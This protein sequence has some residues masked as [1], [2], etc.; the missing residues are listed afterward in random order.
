MSLLI[1]YLVFRFRKL[2]KLQ[3]I[4]DNIP[5]WF[6]QT[7]NSLSYCSKHDSQLTNCLVQG[8]N[9]HK[10]EEVFRTSRFKAANNTSNLVK[11]LWSSRKVVS[12]P[13]STFIES[14]VFTMFPHIFRNLWNYGSIYNKAECKL[15]ACISD[16]VKS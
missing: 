11:T 16:L 2:Y 3:H 6:R 14:N 8:S 1:F 10:F 5:Q 13:Y 7:S 12:F 15:V 9:M 4:C